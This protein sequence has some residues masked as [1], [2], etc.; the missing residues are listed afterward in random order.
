[1]FKDIV[2]HR[3]WD[4]FEEEIGKSKIESAERE[5]KYILLEQNVKQ[6]EY[7]KTT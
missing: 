1:M 2:A 3:K 5:K 7:R 6:K 4:Y